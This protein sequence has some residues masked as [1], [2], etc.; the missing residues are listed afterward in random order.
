MISFLAGFYTLYDYFCAVHLKFFPPDVHS[1]LG[2]VYSFSL[3]TT[4]PHV[5]N[6]H[7]K[8]FIHKQAWMK[9]HTCA[10]SLWHMHPP[11]KPIWRQLH[12]RLYTQTAETR[13]VCTWGRGSI[14]TEDQRLG[15]GGGWWV[16]LGAADNVLQ[17]CI[18]PLSQAPLLNLLPLPLSLPRQ[19]LNSLSRNY[20]SLGRGSF[21]PAGAPERR[22]GGQK[23]RHETGH[24]RLASRDP[25]EWRWLTRRWHWSSVLPVH[26]VI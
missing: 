22:V 6:A 7:W 26:Y 19:R 12:R 16:R 5:C 18:P 17:V 23:E 8:S 15:W 11:E 4:C 3:L 9:T 24:F 25:C 20:S 2:H 13:S 14:G 10:V 1:F 21:R